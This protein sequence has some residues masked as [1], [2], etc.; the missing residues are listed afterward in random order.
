MT[1]NYFD[2]TTGS[3]GG[4]SNILGNPADPGNNATF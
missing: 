3:N 2:Y 4:P 1:G